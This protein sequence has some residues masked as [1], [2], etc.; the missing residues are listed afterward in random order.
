MADAQGKEIDNTEKIIRMWRELSEGMEGRFRSEIDQLRKENNDLKQQIIE[1]LGENELLR[2][3]LRTL[4][5]HSVEEEMV[6]GMKR[7][8]PRKE[9]DK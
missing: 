2:R 9:S 1:V 3:K 7:G 4:I 8:R 5:E 6:S